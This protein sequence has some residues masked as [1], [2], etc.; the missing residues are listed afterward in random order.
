MLNF[1]LF[2]KI[3]TFFVD[4]TVGSTISEYT[5]KFA[6][7]CCACKVLYQSCSNYYHFVNIATFIFESRVFFA[8][9]FVCQT[10]YMYVPGTL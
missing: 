4:F 9:F 3:L 8:E 7:Y 5:P 2:K 6:E 10:M 1:I